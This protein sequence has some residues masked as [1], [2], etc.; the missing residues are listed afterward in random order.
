MPFINK[1]KGTKRSRDRTE[2]GK[3]TDVTN[4]SRVTS[5]Q[6]M[7]RSVKKKKLHTQNMC[8]YIKIAPRCRLSIEC[9]EIK[10][11]CRQRNSKLRG[12]ASNK[13][14]SKSTSRHWLALF[15]PIGV[16]F[17]LST[18]F[19]NTSKVS[20]CQRIV[21]TSVKCHISAEISLDYFIPAVWGQKWKN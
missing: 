20:G 7:S 3:R 16:V 12:Q 2:N 19:I 9:L 18:F 6:R 21:N 8:V 4:R 1:S 17:G 11:K 13:L 5:T 15:W 10:K 14:G